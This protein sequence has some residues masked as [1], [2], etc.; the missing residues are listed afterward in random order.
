M[1]KLIPVIIA[2]LL[3]FMFPFQGN[4]G[5][6]AEIIVK[7]KNAEEN[8]YL[9]FYGI[10]TSYEIVYTFDD[11]MNGY[12]I[13]T[14]P[15]NLDAIKELPFVEDACISETI[16]LPRIYQNSA[17]SLTGA[18][19]TASNL[20]YNG[21]GTV[22][23]V[24][25]SELD[26][27]HE[28][29][30]LS[31]SSSARLKKTDIAKIMTS[32]NLNITGVTANRVYR[33][34][35]IPFAYD[36]CEKDVD[37]WDGN[38]I[39]GTHV[40]G[41]AA[42][43]SETLTGIAPEA[44]IIFMKVFRTIAGTAL[45]STADVFAAVEDAVNFGVSAIN[46]SLGVD[47]ALAE[48][49]S[50]AMFRSIV[51]KAKE[52]GVIISCSSG[53]LGR[54]YA[55]D[56]IP[57]E[58]TDYGISSIP[59]GFTETLSV[60]SVNNKIYTA[61][62]ITCNGKTIPID[63]NGD[64]PLF[65]DC[66]SDKEYTY[67]YASYGTALSDYSGTSNKIT[68]VEAY[69]P[70]NTGISVASKITAAKNS[71]A[72][73]VIVISKN[74]SL[75][76]L[77]KTDIPVC[78]ISKKDGE[79]LKSADSQCIKAGTSLTKFERNNIEISDYSQYMY[80]TDLTLSVDVC[81]PGGMIYSSVPDDL[82]KS[83]SGTSMAAPQVTGAAA[84]V[85]SYITKTFPHLS[86]RAKA[87]L[88][89]NLIM[90]AA[91][92]ITDENGNYESPMV[93]GTGLL[94]LPAALSSNAILYGSDSKTKISLKDKLS[95]NFSLSFTKERIKGENDNYDTIQIK[96]FTDGY[97]T[98]DEINFIDGVLPLSS[99]FSVREESDGKKTAYS[100]DISLNPEETANHT[101][102]YKNGFFLF[103]YVFLTSSDGSETPLS[104]PFLGYYGSFT[105]PPVFDTAGNVYYNEYPLT[106]MFE[107]GTKTIKPFGT[108]V[109][110]GSFRPDRRV[111]SPNGDGYCDTI[112]IYP[113]F[114]RNINY[115]YLMLMRS[116]YDSASQVIKTG[117]SKFTGSS[118]YNIPVVDRFTG[119]I[120]SDG[121]YY[122][123]LV[124]T[125]DFNTSSMHTET[126]PVT[127]DT[128]PPEFH[129]IE[130]DGED[131]VLKI[132]DN[133]Y[134]QAI[135]MEAE[136][137]NGEIIKETV[138]PEQ[139]E[140]GET[141]T[142]VF[143]L[144]DADESTLKF[145]VWDYGFNKKTALKYTSG[146]TEKIPS[147]T[148]AGFITHTDEETDIYFTSF[149]EDIL[150][151]VKIFKNASGTSGGNNLFTVNDSTGILKLFFWKQG[152]MI[153]EEKIPLSFILI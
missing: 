46:L 18:D 52:K 128:R 60:G 113:K 3:F 28:V 112:Y 110:D 37:V 122:I 86:G 152:S 47:Y 22:I 100:V 55:N 147:G 8:S 134:I 142:A 57:V 26:V 59:S 87:T 54:G 43:N 129:S 111:V 34:P 36:Y 76:A 153:P 136:T 29:F 11:V 15:S 71:G 12:V 13:K 94:N 1:K 146:A 63:Q 38:N 51:D 58:N 98:E 20:G 119:E 83:Y 109:F 88:S 56:P 61:Y 80:N 78:V 138:I 96:V 75:S 125:L 102:I 16:E 144:K 65:S 84:L 6:E 89:E 108:N 67:H 32:N 92:P 2:S 31:D 135:V 131:I 149:S 25:D 82:Y 45:G 101:K 130:K 42:G 140:R 73:G 64:S 124:A 121:E 79:I 9:S 30:Q 70:K 114:L 143:N 105:K 103:G 139:E 81:A 69:S 4:S 19:I 145:T 116:E 53:N 35:K 44:Q 49:S 120:V 72:S 117:I 17:T 151:N 24:I 93:Q 123:K 39:H 118:Y 132:S 106:Y 50:Y 97:R 41:I 5:N 77:P 23:A 115:L 27:N 133:H 48:S 104:I 10:D 33:N 85:D 141:V 126:F 90:S 21:E 99:S 95:D 7:T 74:N 62:T 14:D 150:T 40:A 107:N 127:F 148:E 68:L 66:F 137:N 91:V